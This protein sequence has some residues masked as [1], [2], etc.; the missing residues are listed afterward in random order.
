MTALALAAGGG[1]RSAPPA[2]ADASC[3]QHRTQGQAGEAHAGVGQER[4]T[5]HARA[6]PRSV[7]FAVA[8]WG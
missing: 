8:T 4:S 3:A 5:G 6:A 2:A 1:N 7:R